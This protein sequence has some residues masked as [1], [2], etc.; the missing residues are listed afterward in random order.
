MTAR[1][2]GEHHLIQD[3]GWIVGDYEQAQFLPDN[4]LAMR[5]QMHLVCGWSRLERSYV[6]LAA[7]NFGRAMVMKGAIDGPKL[8][9]ET[10]SP[11]G[12]YRLTWDISTPDVVRWR[13]EVCLDDRGWSLVESYRCIP[14]ASCPAS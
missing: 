12:K 11:T 10:S 1:G 8:I 4:S 14:V 3:G 6:A 9:F 2:S 13:N 5:W 7:D